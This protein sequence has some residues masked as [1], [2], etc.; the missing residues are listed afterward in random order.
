MPNANCRKQERRLG[1]FFQQFEET[2]MTQR[3][4]READVWLSDEQLSKLSR[5]DEADDLH[6]PIPTQMVSNGEHMPIPQTEQQSRVEARI[7]E[8]ADFAGKKLGISRRKFLSTTGGM[9]AGL[10]AMNEVYGQFF[11]VGQDELFAGEAFA[12]RGA[13]S[14]LFVLDDQLHMVRSSMAGPQFFRAFAQGP[15]AAA[16]SV[17]KS[18]PF[19]VPGELDE[20][21]HAWP[22]LNPQIVGAEINDSIFHLMSF[23]KDIFFDSQTTVGLLSNATLGVFPPGDPNARPPKNITEAQAAASLTAAQTAAV[24]NFVNRISGSQ[25][26]L[27]HGQIYPGTPSLD[28]MEQ[29]IQQNSP[30]SWKGYTVA[31]SAKVDFDP[32]SL[33]RMWR[34]DDE[35]IAYP[36]YALIA[37][38]GEQLRDHPGFWNICIH[39]GFSPAPVDTPEMGNPTD[40]PKAAR[41]WPQF[42]FIIYH[43]CYGGMTPFLWPS[44][45]LANIM[46]GRLRNGVPDIPWLTQFG[47]TCGNIPNVIAEIGS[48]FAG[49]VIT[50]PT[51][52]AHILGQLLKYFGEDRIVFGS[53]CSYYGSNQWQIEALWRFQI[54][55]NIRRQYGYPDLTDAAKRKILGLNSARLYRVSPDAG[56]SEQGRYRPVP[57]DYD[58]R[59]PLKLKTLLEFP[60]LTNDAMAQARSI[61]QAAGADPSHTRYGWV[62]TRA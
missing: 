39:K 20:L 38:H 42:N 44:P 25:R 13:P 32:E 58:A 30:D 36:T 50:F 59:I 29:Q 40:I 33:M 41:D 15:T 31:T 43:A 34:L 14:D 6:S 60:G 54:P 51:V 56:V 8:L 4:D 11:D 18:N 17:F 61:Y 28:F 3:G 21:G 26:M 49:C 22:V 45:D 48:T 52:C 23:V 7:K 57:R 2:I 46:A 16:T 47:Q 53:D 27:A 62:R 24:R 5:A 9:A 35:K 55:D 10:L 1:S 37:R 19:Q 12:R